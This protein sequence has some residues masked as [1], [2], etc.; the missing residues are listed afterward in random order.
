MM[1]ANR[2]KGEVA[3]EIGGE[4]LV[5]AATPDGLAR[6]AESV[7]ARTFQETAELAA[8]GG[9]L[10][11]RAG[12]NSFVVTGDGAAAWAEIKPQEFLTF[13]NAMLA[14]LT[15]HIPETD[16]GNVNGEGENPEP[17]PKT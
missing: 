17:S 16:P 15:A 3:V 12:L 13:G 10:A 6:F 5:L 9:P 14:A 11:V 2:A 4:A 7:G 8:G 1:A